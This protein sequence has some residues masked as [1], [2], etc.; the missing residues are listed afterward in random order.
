[1]ATIFDWIYNAATGDLT[2][3]QRLEVTQDSLSSF[4]PQISENP[5]VQ[6]NAWDTVNKVADQNWSIWSF[7][8]RNALGSADASTFDW[9]T[10]LPL[11]AL[12][13]VVLILIMK[14]AE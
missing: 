10:A 13:I 8:T 2:P 11:L 9:K 1:M 3:L 6:K 4:A 12:G 7:L 5:V 14:I